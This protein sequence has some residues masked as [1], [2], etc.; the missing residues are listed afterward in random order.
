MKKVH[1]FILV[2]ILSVI[3]A[4]F[5]IPKD[6]AQEWKLKVLE[7]TS[8]FFKGIA[9]VKWQVKV[10]G[11]DLK[12]IN[13]I[14]KENLELLAI[15]AQLRAENETFRNLEKE[16][17]ELK[18]ALRF[19]QTSSFRL[20]I[21]RVIAREPSTWW[22]YITIDRGEE[23]G[24]QV[25]QAVVS[26]QGLIGKVSAV[27]PGTAKVVLLGD[28]NCRVSATLEGV[29]EQGIVVGQPTEVG[30]VQCRMTF[31]SRTAAI[32][33]GQKV[34]TSGL[35]GVFPQGL[36]IGEVAELVSANDSGGF[37]LYREVLI[38]PSAELSNLGEV[39]VVV[40]RK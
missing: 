7:T 40:G 11:N 1:W 27:T 21:A 37:G 39:F 33:I 31:I 18:K 9:W 13:Q 26:P 29:S 30:G 19:Q 2:I 28:E 35:G 17:Q 4:L 14:K 15:N 22:Q 36:L 20:L 25:D 3:S 10:L 6:V 12:S 8:P 16:N 23:D 24:L 5:L 32:D 38:M 34:Y